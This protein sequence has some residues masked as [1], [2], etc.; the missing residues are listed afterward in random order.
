MD[1]KDFRET[2]NTPSFF[3]PTTYAPG[4]AHPALSQQVEPLTVRNAIV[5]GDA[6]QALNT[7]IEGPVDSW[8]ILE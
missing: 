5:G 2:F 7:L 3:A 4:I 8:E 6:I 1:K